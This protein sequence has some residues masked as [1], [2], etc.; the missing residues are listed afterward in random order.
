[1]KV[2]R[3]VGE[4]VATAKHPFLAGWKLLIV[5]PVSPQGDTV[6]EPLLAVDAAEV[7]IG[8]KVLL[9][10]EGGA[11]GLVMGGEGPVRTVIV[12]KVDDIVMDGSSL[13][14]GS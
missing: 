3:V 12:G 1:M 13:E 7:G 5:Q 11:A 9:V 8:E 14:K 6:G 10:D 2:G 4:V